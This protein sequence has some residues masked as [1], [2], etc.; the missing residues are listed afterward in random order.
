MSIKSI[1][2]TIFFL[3]ILMSCEQV[4][5]LDLNDNVSKVVIEGSITNQAGPYIV[6]ISKS[7]L[8]TDVQKSTID[9][10]TVVISDSQGNLET[11]I[12]LGNGRYTTKNTLG[13]TGVTYTLSVKVGADMFIAKSTMPDLVKFDSI[14]VLKNSFGGEFDFDFIPVY[15]DPSTVG[16]NYRFLLSINDTLLKSHFVLNDEVQNGKVNGQHLQNLMNINLKKNDVVKIEM[17]KIDNNVG[18]Y[19]AVLVQNTDTGPGG[20]ATP[21]NPPTN[22]SGGALGIFSAHTSTVRSVVI[23]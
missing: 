13:K 15:A 18:L 19:F 22:L 16:D 6:N 5:D 21:N 17:Q 1:L 9:N 20:G 11:L 23:K 4:I 3:C 2:Y 10:A 8:L 12:S 14:R 7:A